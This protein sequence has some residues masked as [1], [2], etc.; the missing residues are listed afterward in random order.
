MLGSVSTRR[1]KSGAPGAGPQ[2][3]TLS[4]PASAAVPSMAVKPPSTREARKNTVAAP[5]TRKVQ[6]WKTLVQTTAFTPP[7]AMYTI[8]TTV[9]SAIVAQSGQP[10]S[11]ATARAAAMSR[12]PD[13]RRRVMKKK[14]EP[15]TWLA[16]PKR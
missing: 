9:K 7:S 5:P 4:R 3:I 8:D 16:W 6:A 10:T 1:Q 13:P 2:L 15:V 12:T 11:S 14:T